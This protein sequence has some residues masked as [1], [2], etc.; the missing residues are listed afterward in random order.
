M[1]DVVTVFLEHD[2]EVLLVRR[3]DAVG[4]Y[5]GQWGG[6]SGYVE[7]GTD[8]P[9]AD[10]ERELREEIGATDPELV[11]AGDP[12]DIE[13]GDR[14][15]TVH[16]FR[17]AARNRAVEPNEELTDW[18]WT[19]PTAILDR[20]CVPRLWE[21]YRRVAPTVVDVAE[22]TERG[23]AAISATA[24]TVLR[25][26][27][28]EAAHAGDLQRPDYADH[29][30]VL[31][32]ARRLRDARPEMVAVANRVNRA[33]AT[34]EGL[35][36]LTTRAH[37]VLQNAH[38]ADQEAATAAAELLCEHGDPPTVAT[39]SRSGT[40]LAALRNSEAA[41]VV[42]ESR[43]GREGVAVAET[44][45]GVGHEVTLT[46]DA[47]LPS[48]VAGEVG[49]DPDAAIVGADAVLPDGD[50]VNKVGTHPLGQACHESGVP[51]YVVAARDKMAVED[52]NPSENADAEALYDGEA[53]LS[54][55]N[56]VFDRTPADCVEVVVTEQRPLDED[57]LERL[58]A[59]HR[60][61]ANWD[62]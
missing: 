57:A 38:A 5:Q 62:E 30:A 4:T 58:V 18:E 49:P 17:Y 37:E 44:L 42:A 13:D 14:A 31:D 11:R 41:V 60:A 22:D 40:A 25:D 6:I 43:T 39:L 27:A 7:P 59:E 53:A 34:S 56:P 3:S 23:A 48:V 2:D 54:V 47:A 32:V 46:T 24:L 61:H 10:A 16:P 33:V 55:E 26:V 50:V 20:D 9:Q 1:T 21:T 51:L 35:E 8:D 28:G 29:E 36:D 52:R 12:L 15:W 45:A 19:A